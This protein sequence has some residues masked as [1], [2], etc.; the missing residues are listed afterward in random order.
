[1]TVQSVSFW[2]QDLNYWQQAQAQ[3]QATAADDALIN[4][5]SQAETNLGK[6]LAGIANGQALKRVNSQLSAAVQNVLQGS[7]AT[8]TSSSSTSSTASSSAASSSSGTPAAPAS[9]TGT[10]PVSTS[11]SLATL[12]ILTGGTINIGDGTNVTKYTSTGTDTI[13]NLINAVNSGSAF[14]TASINGNGKLI[15]TARNLKDAVVISGS[16]N[17]AAAIG[18][19]NGNNTFEPTAATPAKASTS[20]APSTSSNR[21]A[22]QSVASL[23]AGSAAS[24]LSA[25]GVSGNLIDMLA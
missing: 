13:G 14:L 19:G 11:T 8:S 7:S 12:G 3:S 1:V 24:F 25:S 4:V 22:A 21:G 6:G 23:N 20:A 15:I 17:D 16:G 10:V 5:M 2:Q 18:F 9:G